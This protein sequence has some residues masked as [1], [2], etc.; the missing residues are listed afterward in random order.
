VGNLAL[1]GGERARSFTIVTT[2]PNELCAELHNRMP[3]VLK[4]EGWPLWLG[5]EP[6]AVPQLIIFLNELLEAEC[7][8][9]WITLEGARVAGSGPIAELI[10]A[11]QQDEAR[12]C[13]MLAGHIKALGETPSPKVGAFYGKQWPSPISPK[14][15]PSLTAARVVRKLREMLP[16][17]RDDRLHTRT[18][19]R[20][21]DRTRPISPSRTRSPPAPRKRVRHPYPASRGRSSIGP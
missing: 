16:R 15:S 18:S 2:T 12:W 5:E 4:P 14:G 11:I 10:Q 8:G 9:T 17:V 1:A 19:P 21:C 13:E 6:A 20:C 7:A 3:V